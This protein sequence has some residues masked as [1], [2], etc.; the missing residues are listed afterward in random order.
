MPHRQILGLSEYEVNANYRIAKRGK[1]YMYKLQQKS[2]KS[3]WH[4]AP[5]TWNVR[6]TPEQSPEQSE[7]PRTTKISIIEINNDH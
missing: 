2:K 3:N 1:E 4:H 7:T 5:G 6:T